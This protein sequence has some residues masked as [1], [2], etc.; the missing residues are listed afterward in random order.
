MP[1]TP[2]RLVSQTYVRLLL[3]CKLVCAVQTL[4]TPAD[5]YHVTF[6][7][8]LPATSALHLPDTSADGG[9]STSSSL[10]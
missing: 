7:A 6:G 9:T 8:E 5:R 1:R 2:L 10:L 4:T 3:T